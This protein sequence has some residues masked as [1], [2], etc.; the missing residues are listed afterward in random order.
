[1]GRV[2]LM[3]IRMESALYAKLYEKMKQEFMTEINKKFHALSQALTK[4]N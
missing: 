3:M 2:E 4:Q 1:M